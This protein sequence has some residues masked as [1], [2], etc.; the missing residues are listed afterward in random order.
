VLD[1]NNPGQNLPQHAI[2]GAI[3]MVQSPMGP[4]SLSPVASALSPVQIPSAGPQGNAPPH[5]LLG[6]GMGVG[7]GMGMAMPGGMFVPNPMAIQRS[8]ILEEF[9][10]NKGKKYDF[11]VSTGHMFCLRSRYS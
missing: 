5:T 6:L 9:R 1:T 8:A 4:G 2:A 10:N 11:R 3:H 7:M